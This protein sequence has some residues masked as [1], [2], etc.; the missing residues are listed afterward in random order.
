[1]IFFFCALEV[2]HMLIC[3]V[4]HL[5]LVSSQL[6]IQWSH[7]G[8]FNKIGHCES[9]SIVGIRSGLPFSPRCFLNVYLHTTDVNLS[10]LLV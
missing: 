3:T 8:G 7:S 5:L 9:I 4:Y 10:E 1:M 2:V 6:Y